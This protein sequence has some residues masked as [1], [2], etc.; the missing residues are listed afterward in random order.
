MGGGEESN[1]NISVRNPQRKQNG[2]TAIRSVSER[3]TGGRE[4]KNHDHQQVQAESKELN[5]RFAKTT[6][7]ML[8]LL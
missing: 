5:L 1:Q 8:S 7:M 4:K 6:V 2:I 3:T